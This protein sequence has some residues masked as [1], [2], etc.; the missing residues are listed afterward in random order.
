MMGHP[1]SMGHGWT[2]GGHRNMSWQRIDRGG[3][4]PRN[5]WGSRFR[6]RNWNSYGF[7]QPWGGGQWIRYYDDALLIDRSGRVL[8][9]RYGYDWNRYGGNWAYGDDG[10]PY[11][12]D[13]A[14][15]DY[16]DDGAGY[17]DD[18]ADGDEDYGPPPPPRC[19]RMCGAPAVRGYGYGYG[20]GPV[21][22]TTTTVTEAPVVETR[23]TYETVVERVRVAPRH[24]RSC[25]CRR[26]APPRAGERG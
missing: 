1:P 19:E 20:Y 21:V 2:G 18:Y 24:R 14:Y 4:V 9:G 8:D 11:A 17:G 3:H 6:I 23:T 7:P 12:D 25:G 10:V 16:G 22:V 15:G 13:G 5:W 26:V